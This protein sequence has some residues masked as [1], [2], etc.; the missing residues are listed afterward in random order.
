[1]PALAVA[2]G[3]QTSTAVLSAGL[4]DVVVPLVDAADAATTVVPAVGDHLVLAFCNVTN[5]GDNNNGAEVRCEFGGTTYARGASTMRFS[6]FGPGNPSRGSQLASAFVVTGDASSELRLV[7]RGLSGGASAQCS[8]GSIVAVPTADLGDFQSQESANSD[9]AVTTPAAGW[10]ALGTDLTFSPASDGDYV[11]VASVEVF[12]DGTSVNADEVAVRCRF[13]PDG[14]PATVQQETFHERDQGFPVGEIQHSYR[15]VT[16]RALTSGTTYRLSVEAEGTLA[17]GNFPGRR[18]RFFAFRSDSVNVYRGEST[19]GVNETAATGPFTLPG[20]SIAVPD[21]GEANVVHS[22]LG[23]TEAQTTQFAD[24][25]LV[26]GASEHPPNGTFRGV[27][28]NGV[29]AADDITLVPLQSHEVLVSGSAYTVTGRVDTYGSGDFS[30]GMLRGG[31]SFV[32]AEFLVI[33]W[34][35]PAPAGFA[36]EA[37]FS[38]PGGGALDLDLLTNP[39]G[40]FGGSASSLSATVDL[41]TPPSFAVAGTFGGSAGSLNASVEQNLSVSGVFG[42]SA[43]S[44]AADVTLPLPVSATFGGSGTSLVANVSGLTV[45]VLTGHVTTSHTTPRIATQQRGLMGQP[46]YVNPEDEGQTLSERVIYP[47]TTERGV[48]TQV[49]SPADMSSVQT[50]GLEVWDSAAQQW[51]TVAGSGSAD[52]QLGPDSQ[53]DEQTW[54]VLSFTPSTGALQALSDVVGRGSKSRRWVLGL[55][56]GQDQ[57]VPSYGYDQIVLNALPA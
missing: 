53:G 49:E 16:E 37:T 28:D 33:A 51:V 41:G 9:A 7:G 4:A 47:A 2:A 20:L 1:M 8:S 26:Q 52:T 45:V 44:L 50:V 24:V 31:A 40:T 29:G 3:R 43:A 14:T 56:G 42:S 11:L 35:T 12:G 39:A 19:G 17:D 38:S 46:W 5:D 27:D 57:R 6:G 48:V 54:H 22:Y 15:W 30:V 32:P 18:V 10:T 34:Q 55:G 25:R 21:P 36:V 23:Q 13:G